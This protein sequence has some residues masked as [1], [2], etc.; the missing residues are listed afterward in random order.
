MSLASSRLIFAVIFALNCVLWSSSRYGEIPRTSF[1]HG[2]NSLVKRISYELTNPNATTWDDLLEKQLTSPV[3]ALAFPATEQ[4]AH[5]QKHC[6]LP[7]TFLSIPYLPH[8]CTETELRPLIFTGL[9]IW[10]V[11]LFSTLGISASDFFTP[12][13][14]TIAQCWAWTKMSPGLAIGE[15]LAVPTSPANIFLRDVGFMLAAVTLL[16][17]ILWDGRIQF[18]ES[19]LMI[20]LYV[21]YVVIVVVGTWL[22]RRQE[23]RRA[24]EAMVR[25]DPLQERY[26]DQPRAISAPG[27][28]PRLLTDFPR[29]P[30]SRTPSPSPSY[31]PAQMPSFSL[32]GALEFR[33]VATS[34]NIFDSPYTPYAGGHYNSIRSRSR[35]L[36]RDI[37][38]TLTVRWILG[39]LLLEC[40]STSVRTPGSNRMAWRESSREGR[41]HS[42]GGSVPSISRTPASPTVSDGDTESQNFQPPTRRQRFMH[43]V[44]R[45]NHRL[46]PSLHSFRSKTV[47]G[48]IA[49]VF[50]SAGGDAAHAYTAG[51]CDSVSIHAP[52]REKT[53]GEEGNLIDF[54][55]E[56]IE[57]ILIAEEEVEEELHG[58]TYSKW[59]TAAQCTFGPLFC[60]MV[61][62]GANKH[63]Q[64]WALLS[65]GIVGFAASVLVALLGANGEHPSFRM[66]RYEVVKTFGF[67][68]GLSDAII[69]GNSLADLVANMSVAVFAPIMGFS[70]CFGG[71]MLNILL[72]TIGLLILLAG[73]LIVVPLNGYHLTRTW[74]IILI[75]AYT[76]IMAI[77]V[78]VEIQS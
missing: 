44:Q 74:G 29:R 68:F 40:L 58:M 36:S 46:F 38:A 6:P 77:N 1:L 25:S 45:V 55:E 11:F 7:K 70:A 10:L 51:G 71:P 2:D 8:Y 12:N 69:V 39:M 60:A 9:I 76:T 17:V 59:L 5:V 33:Q 41:S 67:I 42:R 64:L 47:L 22:E 3:S 20:A 28:P 50:A 23:R 48:Q 57:R 26:T 37:T 4:C 14:A 43:V 19:A 62:F 63:Y 24:H 15:L 66:A 31:T 35:T 16:L 52:S 32:V 56:G 54:E 30:Y 21:I 53:P 78:V 34:L 73:T 49:S 72:V 65:A 18:W 13:L 75:A 61:L 27:A